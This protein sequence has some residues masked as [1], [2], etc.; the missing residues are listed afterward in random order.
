GGELRDLLDPDVLAEVEAE[1]QQLAP[2][3]QARNVDE[4]HDLLRRLGE[5]SPDEIAE[6]CERDL[7]AAPPRHREHPEESAAKTPQTSSETGSDVRPSRAELAPER[8]SDLGAAGALAAI[9]PL[10]DRLVE[11]GRAARVRIAGIDRVIAA[12]DAARYR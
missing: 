2:G 8:S 4:I 9:T 7:L 1:L 3:R 5:L 12:E 10:I 11:S 6:R